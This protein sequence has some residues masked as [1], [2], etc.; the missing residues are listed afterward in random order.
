MKIRIFL[1]FISIFYVSMASAVPVKDLYRASIKLPATESE[2][3]MLSDAFSQAVE[4][5]LVRVSGD[6]AAITGDLLQEAQKVAPTW[7]AQHSVTSLKDLL[8]LN[9]DLVAG[10]QVNVFFYHESIDQFLTQHNLPVWGNNRPSVLVWA[11]DDNNGVRTLSGANSPSE[12][13]ND[14]AVSSTNYGVPIYAPLMDSVD[15]AAISPSDVW[16]FFEDTIK[17][18]SQRYQTD[19]IAALRV[20]QYSGSLTGSLLMIIGNDTQQFSLTG[21]NLQDLADQASADM[22]K[23]LSE[24]YAAVRNSASE[25][26]LDLSVSGVTN[27][28]AMQKIQQYLESVGVVRDVYVVKATSNSVVFSVAINGDKQKLMDSIQLSSLLQADVPPSV[29]VPPVTQASATQENGGGAEIPSA[30]T[31]ETTQQSSA[32]SQ[33]PDPVSSTDSSAPNVS[34]NIEYFKYSGAQ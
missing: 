3:Q 10:K 1:F 6:K 12:L 16:G 31:V 15:A 23:A 22:A 7:V 2:D 9:G 14:L 17:S 32:T 33:A 28:A 18:A 11:V 21:T 30:N 25:S 4:Q 24:R 34:N 27:Y 13:L 19:A 29:T 5:V 20:S 8:P 26:R